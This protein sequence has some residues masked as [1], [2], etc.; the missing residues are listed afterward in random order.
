MCPIHFFI[1][2]PVYKAEKYLAAC[3]ESVLAQTYPHFT[4]IAVDDGS[5]DGSGKICDAYAEKDSRI[6]VI[7]QANGGSFAARAAGI[8]YAMKLAQPGDYLMSLDADDTYYPHALEAVAKTVESS[9]CDM[10]FYRH[11]TDYFGNIQ[12][13]SEAAPV[14][15]GIPESKREFYKLVFMQAGFNGL[16]SKA[17]SMKLISEEDLTEPAFMRVSEDLLQSIPFYCK[18]EKPVFISDALLLY[19]IHYGSATNTNTLAHFVNPMPAYQ[20]VWKHMEQEQQWTQE[21]FADYLKYCRKILSEPIWRIARIETSY[22]E[23]KKL[24]MQILSDPF[25][26]KILDDTEAKDFLLQSVRKKH[27][28]TLHII[29]SSVKKVGNI[30]RKIKKYNTI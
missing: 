27:F 26:R 22:R 15:E 14:F 10:V 1:I 24:Y 16:W 18:S 20:I 25:C 30:R 17:I 23:K 13:A 6:H 12:R 9:G 21:D 29:G 28:V 3:L 2:I 5:P 11:D 19:R 7:H 4:A 8:R